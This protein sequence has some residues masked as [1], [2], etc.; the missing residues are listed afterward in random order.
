MIRIGIVILIFLSPLIV[1]SPSSAVEI[2]NLRSGLVCE[3]QAD[4]RG[5]KLHVGWI[6]V[7]TEEIYVTGQGRCMFNQLW[8]PCVWYGFEFDYENAEEGTV[9]SC[10]ATW[11]IAGDEGGPERI[12]EEKTQSAEWSFSLEP[13]DG[14]HFWP[15]YVT[16]R[17]RLREAREDT[18]ETACSIDGEEVFR[19]RITK[20]F[21]EI[22]REILDNSLRR[23]FYLD[24]Q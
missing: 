13:G 15:Q 16:L 9:V 20:I 5:S 22:N 7:D 14:H 19:F 6:C 24:R 2:Q 12:V 1:I 21:P 10:T 11:Q 18:E 4:V 17:A 8:E 3:T 23:A